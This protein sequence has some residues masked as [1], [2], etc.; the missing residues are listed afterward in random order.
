MVFEY[1]F[2]VGPGGELRESDGG[3]S[4]EFVS[5]LREVIID[6]FEFVV[7]LFHAGHAYDGAVE[8]FL[9][10]GDVVLEEFEFGGFLGFVEVGL[11]FE[12]VVGDLL[13]EGVDL[14]F[15]H[16]F[17]LVEQ[18]KVMIKDRDGVELLV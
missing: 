8:H 15:V 5:L 6:E 12:F 4:G 11:F 9:E 13:F 7:L 18:L 14:V 1:F 17:G 16:E 2:E 3:S 10:H